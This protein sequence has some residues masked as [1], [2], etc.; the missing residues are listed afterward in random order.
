[1]LARWRQE[2]EQLPDLCSLFEFLPE[3]LLKGLSHRFCCSDLIQIYLT[4]N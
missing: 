2:Q 1:M 4:N 3:F